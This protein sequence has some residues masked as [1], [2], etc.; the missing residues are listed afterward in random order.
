MHK[1]LS[2]M[3]RPCRGMHPV[4]CSPIVG[5]DRIALIDR[6]Q[7]SRRLRVSVVRHCNFEC[8]F[9]HNEGQGALAPLRHGL[10]SEQF[11]RLCG[12][13]MEAGIR[14]IKLTGGEPLLFKQSDE[15]IVDLVR[16]IAARRGGHAVGLSMT[17]NGL[18]L[19]R[20][21]EELREAGLDRVT[22]SIHT[23]EEG[24]LRQ[25]VHHAGSEK[26]I[27]RILAGLDAAS[28]AGLEPLKVNTVIFGGDDRRNGNL[29][30]LPALVEMCRSRGVAELRLYTLL[31]HAEFY[32]SRFSGRYRFWEGSTLRQIS[33]AL[34][35]TPS[36]ASE[37]AAVTERF[38]EKWRG[39]LYPKP[40]L[41]LDIAGLTV[42]I[43]AMANDRFREYD[44]SSEG[45]YALRLSASGALR[46]SLESK[47]T[48]SLA[49]MLR[50]GADNE[51][52]RVAFAQARRSLLPH[53]GNEE[54][55][56]ESAAVGVVQT[57]RT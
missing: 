48:V 43:E 33:R 35:E 32:G 37:I 27:S 2:V 15:D 44:L 8:F 6:E 40:T 10:S 18:L 41:H 42:C 34:A 52:L 56:E 30:E 13:A 12:A 3:R 14:E 29:G 19:E 49:R 7:I 57:V 1:L 21:A 47:R 39:T 28:A 45:A 5:G 54:G 26:T 38:V 9:C 31:S 51:E 20:R 46:G 24:T 16:A 23:L 36:R 55:G 11:A 25:S 50:S 17:T 22:V 53:A 4:W